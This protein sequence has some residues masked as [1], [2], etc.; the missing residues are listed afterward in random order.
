[1]T[2]DTG[3][4]IIFYYMHSLSEFPFRKREG[5][6]S[7]LAYYHDQKGAYH[8]PAQQVVNPFKVTSFY[9]EHRKE[10][11]GENLNVKKETDR[12]RLLMDILKDDKKGLKML[13]QVLK[14]C[15]EYGESIIKLDSVK[16]LNSG[17]STDIYKMEVGAADNYRKQKHN[18]LIGEFARMR[19]YMMKNYGPD[20]EIDPHDESELPATVLFTGNASEVP[21]LPNKENEQLMRR[22]AIGRNACRYFEAIQNLKD[23]EI[24]ILQKAINNK[25]RL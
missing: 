20:G 23:S 9:N 10:Y 11:L 12:I 3:Y 24:E 5:S 4:G 14:S 17:E 16:K 18:I 21:S 7:E 25:S 22:K 13:R 6:K 15:Q 1:M 8:D 2:R 19:R